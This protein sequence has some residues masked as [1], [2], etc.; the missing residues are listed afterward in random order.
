[1]NRNREEK[2]YG[3][4]FILPNFYSLSFSWPN[5]S[6]LLGCVRVGIRDRAM[7]RDRDRVRIDIWRIEIRQNEK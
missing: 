6:Y 1:M 7:D 3:C 4:P 2:L 5:S